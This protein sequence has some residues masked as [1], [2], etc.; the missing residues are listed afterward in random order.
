M[1]RHG[2]KVADS[3]GSKLALRSACAHATLGPIRAQVEEAGDDTRPADLR[4]AATTALV[5]A[6]SSHVGM[7]K[8]ALRALTSVVRCAPGRS[9]LDAMDTLGET[10]GTPWAELALAAVRDALQAGE[11]TGAGRAARAWE[12]D[13]CGH[14]HCGPHIPRQELWSVGYPTLTNGRA[15]VA[16]TRC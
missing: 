3:L 16:V 13:A 7:R 9:V 5:S 6:S 12:V 15:F 4:G 10:G 14:A 11:A 2:A 1:G 8:Y